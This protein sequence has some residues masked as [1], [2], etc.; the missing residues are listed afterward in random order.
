MLEYRSLSKFYL[1]MLIFRAQNWTQTPD[2]IGEIKE[3]FSHVSFSGPRSCTG[4]KRGGTWALWT[5]W[6]HPISVIYDLI[7][8]LK[9]KSVPGVLTQLIWITILNSAVIIDPTSGWSIWGETDDFKDFM[10]L[11][12]QHCKWEQFEKVCAFKCKLW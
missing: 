12:T 9:Y 7:A 6:L 5:S 11:L 2:Y 10:K 4:H 8:W 1:I 3:W